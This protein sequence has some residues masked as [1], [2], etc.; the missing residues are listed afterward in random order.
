[1]PDTAITSTAATFNLELQVDTAADKYKDGDYTIKVKGFTQ[2]LAGGGT[3][4][5]EAAVTKELKITLAGGGSEA[6][7][8][9]QLV[10]KLENPT[11][12]LIEDKSFLLSDT[13]TV[14][15]SNEA[16]EY[17]FK[18]NSLPEG[19]KLDFTDSNSSINS[20]VTIQEIE[21]SYI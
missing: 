9:A 16:T 15:V 11:N 7:A 14:V 13:L 6:P 5:K 12:S 19:S 20:F 1:V 18:F 8:P 3:N 17:S 10:E 2:D 21:G 4:G